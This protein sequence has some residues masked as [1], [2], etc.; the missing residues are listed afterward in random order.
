MLTLI[1]ILVKI[2]YAYIDINTGKDWY[3]YIDINTGKDWV[4][5]H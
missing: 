5:L 4:C 1:L 3:A 2:G